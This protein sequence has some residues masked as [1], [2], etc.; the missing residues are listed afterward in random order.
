MG[1][2]IPNFEGEVRIARR[3]VMEGYGSHRFTINTDYDDYDEEEDD[4][5]DDESW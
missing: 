4:F 2:I 3:G 5:Q 1:R